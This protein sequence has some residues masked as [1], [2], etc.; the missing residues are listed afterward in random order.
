MET[1]IGSSYYYQALRWCLD[2]SVLILGFL[3]QAL[4]SARF[5]VQWIASEKQGRSIVPLSFW[6]LSVGGGGILLIY[7]ILRKDPVFILGQGGGLVVYLR[8]LCLIYKEYNSNNAHN[9]IHKGSE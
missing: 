6:Y 3:G 4:F 2:N 9:K 7:A 8:N 1:A 5:F